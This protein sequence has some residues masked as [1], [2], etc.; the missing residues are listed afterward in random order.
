[1]ALVND[2]NT[3]FIHKNYCMTATALESTEFLVAS[4]AS[5][6]AQKKIEIKYNMVCQHFHIVF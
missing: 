6:L 5:F 1:M 3:A 4:H 2:C